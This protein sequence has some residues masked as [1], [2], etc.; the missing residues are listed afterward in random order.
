MVCRQ[1]SSQSAGTFGG[2]QPGSEVWAWRTV[3][4]RPLYVTRC[5][6]LYDVPGAHVPPPWGGVVVGAVLGGV[7]GAVVGGVVGAV[8]GGVVG[9]VVGAVVGGVVGWVPEPP[10]KSMSEQV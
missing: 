7:V 2:S 5:P 8:V 3:Y 10:P 9:G 4:A 1:A 6:R